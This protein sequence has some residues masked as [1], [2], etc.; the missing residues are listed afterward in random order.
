[1]SETFTPQRA[2][3]Y[4][5]EAA[6]LNPGPWIDHCRN[7]A[8]A[9]RALAEALGL[10]ADEA[11]AFGYV[12][13][14]GRRVGV[15]ALR[16]TIDGFTFMMGEGYPEAARICL[17]H[18]FPLYT[19]TKA[20]GTWDTT[21]EEFDFIESQLAPLEPTDMDRLIQLCDEIALPQG[22]TL[23][24][25]RLVDVARRHGLFDCSLELWE[26]YFA[27]KDD[28]EARLG[29]SIYDLFPNLVL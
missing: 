23:L 17:T 18:T 14:I 16:H 15:T 1:M 5:D 7:V 27:I 21:P 6:E 8:L 10:D 20:V 3:V 28:Y 24:E 13:D 22:I 26:A 2:R 25:K 11:E 19:A 9:A 29:H 12:H 4:L